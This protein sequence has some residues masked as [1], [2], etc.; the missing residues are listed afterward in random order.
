MQ[1][2]PADVRALGDRLRPDRPVGLEPGDHLGRDRP[3]QQTLDLAEE[4]RLVD[5]NERDRVASGAGPSRPADP[6]EVVLGHHRQLEVDD[7]RQVLD[8]EAA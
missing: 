2:A 8:V 1:E 3:P 7:V 4:R 5:T 6:M